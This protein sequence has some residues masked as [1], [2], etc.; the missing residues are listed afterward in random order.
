LKHFAEQYRS[1]EG[2]GFGADGLYWEYRTCNFA[3]SVSVFGEHQIG[4]KS[5]WANI[6]EEFCFTTGLSKSSISSS[7]ATQP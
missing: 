1:E 6:Y 2:F 7:H 4:P 5:S 3:Y